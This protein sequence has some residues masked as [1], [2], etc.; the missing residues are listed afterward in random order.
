MEELPFEVSLSRIDGVVAEETFSHL[1]P[2][3]SP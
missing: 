1:V 2:W 3:L